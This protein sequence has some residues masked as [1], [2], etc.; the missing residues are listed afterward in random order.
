MYL[1]LTVSLLQSFGPS[2][3]ARLNMTTDELLLD[4]PLLSWLMQG[5]ILPG[6]GMDSASLTAA[7]DTQLRMAK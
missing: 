4:K 1:C 5:H 6:K 3:K 7:N 2:L